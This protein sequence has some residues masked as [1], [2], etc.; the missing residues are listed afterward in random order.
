ML[1]ITATAV[2]ND[3]VASSEFDIDR[4]RSEEPLGLLYPQHPD[5]RKSVIDTAQTPHG[6]PW[7][8]HDLHRTHDEVVTD[9]QQF[10]HLLVE[11]RK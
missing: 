7:A 11:A 2:N 5:R 1:Q 9:G 8:T 3:A 4:R 10:N 6:W